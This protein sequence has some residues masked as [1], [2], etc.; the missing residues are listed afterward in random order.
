MLDAPVFSK[1]TL[2][3]T[4]VLV[5]LVAGIATS[6]SNSRPILGKLLA[7]GAPGEG[8]DPLAGEELKNEKVWF[9]DLRGRLTQS[10]AEK[11]REDASAK[12]R[13]FGDQFT[14]V[15]LRIDSPG[16]TDGDL[17]PATHIAETLRKD[18]RGVT[19]VAYIIKNGKAANAAA[20]VAIACRRLIMGP[21]ALLGYNPDSDTEIG[22][23][24]EHDDSSQARAAMSTY[25]TSSKRKYPSALAEALVSKFHENVWEVKFANFNAA[26][27]Q[28]DTVS[29]EILSDTDLELLKAGKRARKEDQ[30]SV[31]RNDNRLTL[32]ARDAL[33]YHVSKKVVSDDFQA[34]RAFG[35][36][37]GD[38]DVLVNNTGPI[39]PKS[40]AAQDVVD[41]LNNFVVRFVLLACAM[42]GLL[43]EFKMPGTFIPLSCGSL[44]FVLFFVGGF[45]PA[46]GASAPTAS[47]FEV[48]LC[49]GGLS[50]IAIE[51]FVIPGIMIFA[52]LGFGMTLVSVVL[53]MV[54]PTGITEVGPEVTGAI[55]TLS[56]AILVS[57]STFVAVVRYLP[58]T[59]FFSQ[60]GFVSHA[61][62]TGTP[63]GENALVSQQAVANLLGKQGIALTPL[64][65]A[66]K[67]E[68]D[69]QVLDV[70]SEGEYVEK[71]VEVEVIESTAF[72]V[73]V[74]KIG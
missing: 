70:V 46:T 40:E 51:L 55:W 9:Y 74:R 60:S 67:V 2:T 66:G 38:Q 37:V 34:R 27:P 26:K 49:V 4:M 44:C 18:L 69:G 11:F 41:F 36:M 1:S 24:Q 52:L 59:A 14:W 47:L 63:T 6:G 62:I 16:T 15:F 19:S 53:A 65:P 71:G 30:S 13:E 64:N 58:Q 50:L 21:G 31:V 20:L 25:V 32:T 54:P 22:D 29:T 72:R 3:K 7:Q 23:R 12:K 39:Q 8:I 73:V 56:L 10:M 42:I 17:G 68:A 45:F 61:S 43:L 28:Q 48:L 5:T 57:F 33:R 35:I